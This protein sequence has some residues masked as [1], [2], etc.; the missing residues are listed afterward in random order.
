MDTTVLDVDTAQEQIVDLTD[1][2]RDVLPRA[3]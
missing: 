1:R 2:V 3:G